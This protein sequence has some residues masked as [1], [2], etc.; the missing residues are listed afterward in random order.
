MCT[1]SQTGH[2]LLLSVSSLISNLIII[3]FGFAPGKQVVGMRGT[4]HK[5]CCC[6]DPKSCPTL[7]NPGIKPRSAASLL[8]WQVDSLLLRHQRGLQTLKIQALFFLVYLT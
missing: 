3:L 1:A 4:D 2:I 5:V 7:P 6:L 8:H